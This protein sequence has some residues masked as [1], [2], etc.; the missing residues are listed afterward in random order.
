MISTRVLA[1]LGERIAEDG[2]LRQRPSRETLMTGNTTRLGGMAW[3]NRTRGKLSGAE[4]RR[5]LAPLAR[6]HAVNAVGRT[7]MAL[8][9]H[10]GRRAQ[11][12]ERA[13]RTSPSALTETAEQ[14][15]HERLTPAVLNHSY[16]CYSYGVAI[17]ALE[18]IDVDRGLLFAAAMLHDTGLS[19]PV[20][21]VDFTLASA[22]IALEVA[23]TVG[24]STAATET[25]LTAMT[26]S[27]SPHNASIRTVAATTRPADGASSA[28]SS[29]SPAPGIGRGTPS[30]STSTGPRRRISMTGPLRG[31]NA[32]ARLGCRRCRG[33]RTTSTAPTARGK[34]S[35]SHPRQRVHRSSSTKGRR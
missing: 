19:A 25:M 3:S 8:R 14:V 21:G 10:S 9:V 2:R 5:L 11:V 22:R 31:R 6:A 24:L 32:N 7:A 17:A 4:T 12:P 26:G 15:A 23:E 13:L 28:N 30:T 33:A 35:D 29:R 27:C 18:D 20:P 16:R 1:E 34:G